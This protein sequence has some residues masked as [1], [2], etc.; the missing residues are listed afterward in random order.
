[1]FFLSN[2]PSEA[3]NPSTFFFLNSQF[4]DLYT[5]KPYLLTLKTTTHVDLENFDTTEQ[6]TGKDGQK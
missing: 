5:A 4:P 2:Q 3:E 1:M 6:I